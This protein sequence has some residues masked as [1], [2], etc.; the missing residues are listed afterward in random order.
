VTSNKDDTRALTGYMI[1]Y[2][3]TGGMTIKKHWSQ[4]KKHVDFMAKFFYQKYE[5]FNAGLS[6]F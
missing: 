5:E 2:G 3:R 4:R 6:T 1:R